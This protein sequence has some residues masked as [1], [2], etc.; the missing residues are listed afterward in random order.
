MEGQKLIVLVNTI[1][2]L[3]GSRLTETILPPD[4]VGELKPEYVAPLVAYLCHESNV[5]TGQVFE[6][7]AGW[8][9][10]LRWQRGRGA[11]LPLAKALTPE[12]VAD[13]WATIQ[14]FDDPT[15]PET[16]LDSFAPVV[17][18]LQKSR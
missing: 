8:A 18:S 3:A 17:E 5:D 16:P 1:A 13:Q 14:N 4:M 11:L 2:P 15:Y 10:R 7:G 9:A 6:V 12:A